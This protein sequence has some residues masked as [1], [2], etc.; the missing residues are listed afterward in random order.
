MLSLAV[1]VVSIHYDDVVACRA[2][3]TARSD[4]PVALK[5][6][7]SGRSNVAAHFKAES[8]VLTRLRESG[9]LNVTKVISRESGRY[10]VRSSSSSLLLATVRFTRVELTLLPSARRP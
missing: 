7:L 8:A 9:I 5:F 1:R 4:V 2:I 10:G 3:S 6:S